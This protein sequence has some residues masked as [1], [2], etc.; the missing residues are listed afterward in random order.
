MNGPG[1]HVGM[2]TRRPLRRQRQRGSALVEY[3][4]VVLFLIVVLLA[5]DEGHSIHHLAEMLR[6]AYANFI[7][8]LSISWV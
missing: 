4:I 8:A 6:K 2:G 5:A 7:Y 3:T 1:F